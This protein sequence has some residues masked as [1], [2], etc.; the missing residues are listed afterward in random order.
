MQLA[1]LRLS[2]NDFLPPEF[3]AWR[4]AARAFLAEDIPPNEASWDV[5]QLSLSARAMLPGALAGAPRAHVSRR[6]MR[7]AL[8]V[9]CHRDLTRWDLL[10]RV[11]WRLTHGE[12]A[13]LDVAT[14]PDVH[15]L[16]VFDKAVRR[17]AHKMKAFV[18]FRRV[19]ASGSEDGDRFVA[20]F[21]PAHRVVERT[22]PFFIRRFTA[23]HWSILTPDRCVHWDRASATFTDG[24]PR[25]A[26]LADDVLEDL[27]RD[28]YSSVFN[29]ARLAPDVMRAEM[30]K[31]YWKNL[32]EARLIAD[33]S[34]N[35]PS[36]VAQ[37]VARVAQP[38][39]SLPDE[40]RAAEPLRALQR[41][42]P[43]RSAFEIPS[44]DA[45]HDPGP[46]EARARATALPDA[47]GRAVQIGDVSVMPGVAGW[48]DPTLLA[49]GVFYPSDATTPEARLRFYAARYA[50]VEVDSTYYAMPR[51]E[52]AVAWVNRTPPEFIFNVKANALMTG[53]A[54]D[55]RQM[56]DWLRRALP[57]HASNRVYG[58]DLSAG[59]ME[60]LWQRYLAAL[61]PLIRA[62]KLGAVFLQFPRWF[63]PGAKAERVLRDAARRLGDVRGAVEFRN[64]DWV[65]PDERAER[66]FKLLEDCGLA[67]TVVDAPQGTRSSMPPLLRVT[68]PDFA[69]VRLHG[70]RTTT[71]EAKNP[72]VTERYRYLY[73][74][75]QVA[76]W[77]RLVDTLAQMVSHGML[78]VGFNNNHANYAT[79]NAAEFGEELRA[80]RRPFFLRNAR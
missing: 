8:S 52:H 21:E 43:L 55:V 54:A 62:K 63:E 18:R 31:A 28:Y 71:W 77:A 47:S 40:Y 27:W 33:L 60:E 16:F 2:P 17:A 67:Y 11:L 64:P 20:W 37:M 30:P 50:M 75:E 29:P 61:E 45:V 15:Q 57:R 46:E 22:A 36:R 38:A 53:H 10:Y 66:T 73:S 80:R 68:R 56:P 3:G 69:V 1:D 49:P 5:P 78:Q 14:D 26:S 41:R 4:T 79:T 35:A 25:P 39:E 65:M 32:P 42:G 13:L 59:L 23:M 9:A 34:R 48:T 24:I 72:F 51:R 58:K 7:I 6:Y 70:R 44:W 19:A 12:P 76:E 74:K